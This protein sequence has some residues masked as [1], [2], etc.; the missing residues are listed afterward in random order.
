MDFSVHPVGHRS[1][2]T[3]LP[4]GFTYTS[5]FPQILET[6]IV[7]T[8]SLLAIFQESNLRSFPDNQPKYQAFSCGLLLVSQVN[9]SSSGL[10]GNDQNPDMPPLG[11]TFQSKSQLTNHH[12][13][14][15]L[16]DLCKEALLLQNAKFW[17]HQVERKIPSV[18]ENPFPFDIRLYTFFIYLSYTLPCLLFYRVWSFNFPWNP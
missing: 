7:P 10:S 16:M 15:V 6:S 13:W 18:K 4:S 12:W 1:R 11:T 5:C 14:L 9:P 3:H 17:R 8:C 2:A